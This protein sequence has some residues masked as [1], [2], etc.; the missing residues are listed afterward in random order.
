MKG[1]GLQVNEKTCRV[2][3]RP[4]FG[5][6]AEME[7]AGTRTLVVEDQGD[8]VIVRAKVGDRKKLRGDGFINVENNDAPIAKADLVLANIHTILNLVQEK[9]Q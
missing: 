7:Y 9:L 5:A 6:D 2:L 8:F 1:E 3:L 4:T